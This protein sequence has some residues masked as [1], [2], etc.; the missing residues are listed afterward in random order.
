MS[1]CSSLSANTRIELCCSQ[2]ASGIGQ[3]VA[4]G[5]Q[6]VGYRTNDCHWF[7]TRSRLSLVGRGGDE[8]T[9]NRIWRS[10]HKSWPMPKHEFTGAFSFGLRG[11]WPRH[12]HTDPVDAASVMVPATRCDSRESRQHLRR[13]RGYPVAIAPHRLRRER[14]LRRA[15]D[16]DSGD[17]KYIYVS[18]RNNRGIAALRLQCCRELTGDRWSSIDTL[19]SLAQS[20]GLSVSMLLE[21]MGTKPS[22]RPVTRRSWR[23]GAA[24]ARAG[25]VG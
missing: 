3:C 7:V 17:G 24:S 5:P 11:R 18:L 25:P 12:L 13:P 21:R 23:R 9:L 14:N 1:A 2:P 16:T 10:S 22:S 6:I 19:D 4:H 15:T 8:W 20:C